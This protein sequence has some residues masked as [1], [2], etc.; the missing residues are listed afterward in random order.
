MLTIVGWLWR[1]PNC[2]TQYTVDHVNTWARMIH[3]N[4]TLEHRFLVF[5]D[6][7]NDVFDPPIEKAPLWKE[8]HLLDNPQWQGDRPQCYVRL[9]AFSRA[10]EVMKLLGPRYVSIDLDCVVMGNLD[11]ILGRKEPF[12]I[13]KRPIIDKRKKKDVYNG[14]LW[15]MDTG[16]RPEVWEEFNGAVS[17][18]S[19]PQE[20]E[21]LMTDQGWLLYKLGPKQPGWTE[22]DGVFMWSWLQRKGIPPPENCKII[23]FNGFWKPWN[24]KFLDE[25]YR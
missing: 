7:T 5:T 4:L 21:F 13:W 11:K 18:S 6:D 23:F 15:M 9:Q 19:I 22:K 10:P 17:T 1:D 24:Y 2:R 14:S 3:R 16:C 8:W 25:V 20:K 12:L